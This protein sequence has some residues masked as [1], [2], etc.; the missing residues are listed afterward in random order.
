MHVL[1]QQHLGANLQGQLRR[2]S[3][4]RK[5]LT[6]IKEP[7]TGNP[8]RG[9]RALQHPQGLFLTQHIDGYMPLFCPTHFNKSNRLGDLNLLAGGENATSIHN[10]CVHNLHTHQLFTQHVKLRAIHST[11]SDKIQHSC[12]LQITCMTK[13][14]HQQT[15][16]KLQKWPH[17]CLETPRRWTAVVKFPVVQTCT[18]SPT[19]KP[20]P[21]GPQLQHVRHKHN[22]Q[23]TPRKGLAPDRTQ[24]RIGMVH[25]HVRQHGPFIND[26][27]IQRAQ[28]PTLIRVH[29][30]QDLVQRHDPKSNTQC[31]MHRPSTNVDGRQARRASQSNVLLPCMLLHTMHLT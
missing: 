8:P 21:N 26:D 25:H 7:V 28:V 19:L 29:P 18:R 15:R 2:G 31:G 14:C 9:L 12:P 23:P 10:R 20:L 6:P 24:H 13:Q 17:S 22:L 27:G 30:G 3:H 11:T 4:A 1:Q 16:N 5:Q